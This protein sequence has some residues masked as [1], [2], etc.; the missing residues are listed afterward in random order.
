MFFKDF[1]KKNNGL[2]VMNNFR[3]SSDNNLVFLSISGIQKLIN[4][5]EV[6]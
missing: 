6:N 1:V 2:K 3:Y 5:S 4:S